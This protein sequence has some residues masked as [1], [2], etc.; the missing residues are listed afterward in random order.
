MSTTIKLTIYRLSGYEEYSDK[1]CS[2]GDPCGSKG[3]SSQHHQVV[4]E[5]ALQQNGHHGMDLSAQENTVDNTCTCDSDMVVSHTY[6]AHCAGDT[7]SWK[8]NP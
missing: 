2:I 4:G 3:L 5:V 7:S 8:P 1:F 6:L